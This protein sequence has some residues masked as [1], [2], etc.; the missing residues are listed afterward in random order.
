[1]LLH[2]KF[3][4]SLP[5]ISCHLI[6]LM[7][8]GLDSFFLRLGVAERDTEP[9]LECDS[10]VD[11]LLIQGEVESEFCQGAGKRTET[12][13]RKRSAHRRISIRTGPV[14]PLI[15]TWSL[16]FSPI[17][18]VEPTILWCSFSVS[19]FWNS[20]SC[21]WSCGQEMSVMGKSPS[22]EPLKI[23]FNEETCLQTSQA[24]A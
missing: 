3:V 8:C 23:F 22:P 12:W 14:W 9:K 1:M 15:P 10:K 6:L 5:Y 16:F 24:F 18:L 13:S 4:E 17:T 2:L 11:S 20:L 19:Y 7:T 21:I